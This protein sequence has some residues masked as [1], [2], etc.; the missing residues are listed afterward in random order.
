MEIESV[1]GGDTLESMNKAASQLGKLAK[2]VKKTLSKE[3]IARR[4]K[5][6]AEARKKRWP[7]QPS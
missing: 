4:T 3:E 5:R 6:L 1:M 2:G 7:K